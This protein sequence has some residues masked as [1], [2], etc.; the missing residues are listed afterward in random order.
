MTHCHFNGVYVLLCTD[1]AGVSGLMF[2]AWST[3]EWS[4]LNSLIFYL[5]E[6]APFTNFLQNV[7]KFSE[8]DLNVSL[9]Q[10]PIAE[11][12]SF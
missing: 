5:K 4:V 10:N 1:V 3:I 11:K 2:S 8:K 7:L 9:L 12:H 6:L